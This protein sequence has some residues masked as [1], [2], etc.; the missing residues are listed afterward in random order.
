MRIFHGARQRKTPSKKIVCRAFLCLFAV[1]FFAHDK[2]FFHQ[3]LTPVSLFVAFAVRHRKTHA[4][5]I[6]LSA[7]IAVDLTI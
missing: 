7:Q 4:K 1:R 5:H 3:P 6:G 2:H